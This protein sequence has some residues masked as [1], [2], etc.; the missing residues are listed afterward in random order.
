MVIESGRIRESGRRPR[1]C[2]FSLEHLKKNCSSRAHT[3]DCRALANLSGNFIDWRL[4]LLHLRRPLS[5]SQKICSAAIPRQGDSRSEDFDSLLP[6]KSSSAKQRGRGE[7]AGHRLQRPSEAKVFEFSFARKY[8][9][10]YNQPTHLRD[11]T[12]FVF[13]RFKLSLSGRCALP[14]YNSANS[15]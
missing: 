10:S 6:K 9:A 13:A 12:S 8:F 1:T 11:Q 5:A 7:L 2:S 15:R 3:N 14:A 4:F